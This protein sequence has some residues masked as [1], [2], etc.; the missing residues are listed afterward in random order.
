LIITILYNPDWILPD[1][2]FFFLNLRPFDPSTMAEPQIY[3]YD[4]IVRI[5]GATQYWCLD[6]EVYTLVFTRYDDPQEQPLQ[7]Q[8]GKT[9]A[10]A[11]VLDDEEA[12]ADEIK[13]LFWGFMDQPLAPALEAALE[14][15]PTLETLEAC[16]PFEE[17]GS[18]DELCAMTMTF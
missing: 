11:F 14:T 1:F 12:E 2:N 3:L 9:K 4:E 13:D 16:W 7:P 15:L 18:L 17:F 5:D 10:N 8:T 6:D